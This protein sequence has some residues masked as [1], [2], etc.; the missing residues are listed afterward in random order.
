MCKCEFSTDGAVNAKK[1]CVCIVLSENYLR[2]RRWG[3]FS[4]F[5]FTRNVYLGAKFYINFQHQNYSL[6]IPR[7]QFFY[8]DMILKLMMHLAVDKNCIVDFR[9]IQ[10]I[11]AFIR[12]NWL[13]SC[14]LLISCQCTLGK[15]IIRWIALSIQ[16]CNQYLGKFKYT[17]KQVNSH[18]KILGNYML[19]LSFLKVGITSLV[20]KNEFQ[21]N[22]ASV[23]VLE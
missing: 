20:N 15:K 22:G 23:S 18:V 6:M 7:K 3:K 11:P 17:A 21:R 5:L 2:F 19:L 13:S 9:I 14:Q 10:I 8:S 1:N 16:Y 4:L 12:D